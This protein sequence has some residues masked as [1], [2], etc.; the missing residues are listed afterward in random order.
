MET[1]K[2]I[3]GQDWKDYFD[4]FTKRYLRDDRPETA[5]I[6]LLSPSLGD[7]VEVKAARLLGITYDTKSK[8]LEILLEN[9]DHL[10]YRPKKISVIEEDDG[11]IP[12]IEIVR[13]DDTKE[14]LTV[15]RGERR[16]TVSLTPRS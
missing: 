13:D 15:R 1:T 6:E 5:T 8:A 7:Q 2:Q 14:I 9:M 10:V 3:R 4:R 12:S 16:E 11:F